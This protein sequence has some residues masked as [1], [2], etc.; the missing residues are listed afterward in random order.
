MFSETLVELLKKHNLTPLKLA[1]EINVPKSIVYEWKNG[2]REPS[3]ETMKKLS[4]YFGV[5]IE[6]LTG[7]TDMSETAENELIV[8]FRAARSISQSDH[9]MLIEGFKMDIDLYLRSKRPGYDKK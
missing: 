1:K 3:I 8:M 2:E 7:R 5:S 4:D 6:Y 9:D